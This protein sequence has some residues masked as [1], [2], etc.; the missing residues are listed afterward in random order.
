M[1]GTG[2]GRGIAHLRYALCNFGK[3]CHKGGSPALPSPAAANTMPRCLCWGYGDALFQCSGRSLRGQHGPSAPATALD[4]LRTQTGARSVTIHWFNRTPDRLR[5]RWL[6]T[7][8]ATPAPAGEL[9]LL[10]DLNPR[11]IVAVN[12]VH[13]GVYMLE[14]DNCPDA[15][16]GQFHQWQARLREQGLGQFLARASPWGRWAR[17]G[18]RS[19]PVGTPLAAHCRQALIDLM[20][21]V[22]EALRLMI[23]TDRRA[24]ENAMLRHDGPISSRWRSVTMRAGPDRQSGG[25]RPAGRPGGAGAGDGGHGMAADR[26]LR[27]LLL[28]GSPRAMRWRHGDREVLLHAVAL[29]RFALERYAIAGERP[30]FALALADAGR[31]ATAIAGRPARLFRADPVRGRSAGASV[32][33]RR[34]R[35]VRAGA[36]GFDPHRAHA[37]QAGHGQDAGEPPGRSDP[38]GAGQP[39]APVRAIELRVGAPS[40]DRFRQALPVSRNEAASGL[41]R[42]MTRPVLARKHGGIVD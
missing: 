26:G 36:R 2:D 28:S 19:M 22:R 35:H 1:M 6:A 20:P 27:P 40:P 13:D 5:H 34:C 12:P 15:L 24:N 21:H 10:D 7:C 14:D 30:A 38:A 9:S 23:E 29:P 18:L 11:T 42:A 17:P 4:R 41:S 8:S 16:Q 32:R 37:A 3:N 25:A 39:L 33:R 31:T